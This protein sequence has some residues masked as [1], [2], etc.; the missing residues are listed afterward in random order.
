MGFGPGAVSGFPNSPNLSLTVHQ[1]VDTVGRSLGQGGQ[2]QKTLAQTKNR[3]CPVSGGGEEGPV[4]R[5]F[6]AT[7]SLPGQE[8]T[9]GETLVLATSG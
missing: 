5:S 4:V 1:C 7:G 2:Q 3:M 9:G 8:H 6:F